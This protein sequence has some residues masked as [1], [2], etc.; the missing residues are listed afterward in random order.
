[1][2]LIRAKYVST[3]EKVIQVDMSR[4]IQYFTLDVISKVGLGKSFG[5]LQSDQDVDNYIQSSEEG[6]FIGNVALALGFSWLTHLPGI[7]RF[8]APSPADSN[9]FGK[10]MATCF[11]FVDE[12]VANP[13]DKRSDMLASFIRHGLAGHELRTEALEQIIAGSDTT[14]TGI[15]VTL[16][17]IMSNSR[18]Y[19]RL[20]A[21]LDEAVRND[22]APAAGEGVI[23]FAQAKKLPYLQA[24]IREALRL[25]PPVANIFSRDVPPGGDTVQV[26][27]DKYFLPEGTCIGYS[28]YAMHHDPEIFGQDAAAFRPERWFESNQSKLRNMLF[29]N[30]QVFG[31][32]KF[33]CLGQNI[34][35]MELSKL[36][37]EVYSTWTPTATSRWPNVQ[38]NE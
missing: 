36:L 9:G 33:H 10:M 29:T 38:A 4:K 25:N 26:N 35:Q 37:F 3:S 23:S 14:A 11:R 19:R 20:Q 5:M 28:A 7:G 27:E 2:N 12:R 32:G 30:E 1:M 17:H 22:A 6:L 31:S 16:L 34:A 21:E 8:I 15:R 13:T 24:V 18:A